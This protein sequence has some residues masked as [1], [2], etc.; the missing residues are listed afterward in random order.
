LRSGSRVRGAVWVELV[1]LL[2]GAVVINRPHSP[3]MGEAA[4]SPL[5]WCVVHP[6]CERAAGAPVRI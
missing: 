3:G 5:A 1:V 6:R 2:G 4:E